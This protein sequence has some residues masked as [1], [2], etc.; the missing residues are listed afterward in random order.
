[1]KKQTLLETFA[2]ENCGNAKYLLDLMKGNSVLASL[3]HA[4]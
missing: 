1:M 4:S 2:G 3:A